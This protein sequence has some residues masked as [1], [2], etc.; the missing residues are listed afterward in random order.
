[1][2]VHV[3]D[4]AAANPERDFQIIREELEARDPRLLKKTTLVIANKLDLD[5][6]AANL[7]PFQKARK[8]DGLEVVGISARE[9]AGIDLLLE[10]LA[11]LLP[12]AEEL[13]APGE[14]TGVVIHRFDSGGAGY[15][16]ARDPDG[17]YI[18]RGSN[19]ERLAA[20]TDFTNEE[21]AQRF[22][23]TL[24]RMGIERDLQKAGVEE[25]DLV[26]IGSEELEWGEDW[27]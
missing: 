3:V 10:A 5:P 26:R 17:T 20:Q 23:R 21:S 18:V 8:K 25:G 19:I 11:R 24:A 14:A 6:A 9:K 1:M 7:K 12:S 27:A 16:V 15:A 2:L 13:S 22:Q 4:M